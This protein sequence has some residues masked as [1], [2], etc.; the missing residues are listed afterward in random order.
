[1]KRLEGLVSQGLALVSVVAGHGD[2]IYNFE[3]VASDGCQ[4]LE[5]REQRDESS[6]GVIGILG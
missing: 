1:M 5:G 3:E 4:G 2:I 6:T